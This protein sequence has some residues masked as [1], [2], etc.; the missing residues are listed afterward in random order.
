MSVNPPHNSSNA[1][2]SQN[3]NQPYGKFQQGF[4]PAYHQTDTQFAYTNGQNLGPYGSQRP[5]TNDSGFFK[6]LFDF[7]F[8]N[9]ITVKFAKV[10]Y[11]LSLV[12]IALFVLIS[13]LV[14]IAQGLT[15]GNFLM[16]IVSV[17]AG[18]F[19]LII[20][21]LGL[22]FSVAMIRVAQNSTEIRDE[23]RAKK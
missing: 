13:S 9:F 5:I 20:A 12:V 8:S 15:V 17:V 14:I 23:L 3:Q 1:P 2:F 7:S 18:F 6:A 16:L 11:L 21:R 10:I 4:T 22:E 19:Y